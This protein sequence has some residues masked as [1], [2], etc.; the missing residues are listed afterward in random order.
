MR[1]LS[2]FSRSAVLALAVLSPGNLSHAQEQQEVLA[3]IPLERS[4]PE[5]LELDEAARNPAFRSFARSG[6]AVLDRR[7]LAQSVV[8]AAAG[9]LNRSTS[10]ALITLRSI[11]GPPT[12]PPARSFFA[13]IDVAAITLGNSPVSARTFRHLT[14]RSGEVEVGLLQIESRTEFVPD[15]GWFSTNYPEIHANLRCDWIYNTRIAKSLS[16]DGFKTAEAQQEANY[17]SRML[18]RDNPEASRPDQQEDVGDEIEEGLIGIERQFVLAG[19]PCLLT[20]LCGQQDVPCS[21]EIADELVERVV[22]VRT[23]SEP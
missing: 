6:S 1:K 20:Y 5:V 15:N 12:S 22:L 13:V 9:A 7:N 3:T 2:A 14:E 21:D 17:R 4:S 16:D 10:A 19:R 11:D 23:G 18:E 8:K